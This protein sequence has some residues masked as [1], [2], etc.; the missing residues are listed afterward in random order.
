MDMTHEAH[1]LVIHVKSITFHV[2]CSKEGPFSSS[3]SSS[4]AK[5]LIRVIYY[6]FNK[7][8][9]SKCKQ[10]MKNIKHYQYKLLMPEWYERDFLVLYHKIFEG[11]DEEVTSNHLA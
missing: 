11:L 10:C 1:S 7:R 6:V 3:T 4:V 8:Q 5:I 2:I 9:L